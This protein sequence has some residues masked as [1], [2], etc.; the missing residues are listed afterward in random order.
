MNGRKA[1]AL[2]TLKPA[3]FKPTA[4]SSYEPDC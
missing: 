2:M 4:G 1:Y 3:R